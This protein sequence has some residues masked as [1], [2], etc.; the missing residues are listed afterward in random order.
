MLMDKQILR[1]AVVLAA[2]ALVSCANRGVGP[3]GGPKDSIPPMDLSEV[4]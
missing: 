4:Q 3:Q 1:L 2:V